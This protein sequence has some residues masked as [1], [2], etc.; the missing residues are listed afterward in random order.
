MCVWV[1]LRCMPSTFNLHVPVLLCHIQFPAIQPCYFLIFAFIQQWY[2]ILSTCVVPM[3]LLKQFY[4]D[5]PASCWVGKVMVLLWAVQLKPFTKTCS[6]PFSPVFLRIFFTG[7][8]PHT[9]SKTTK[10]IIYLSSIY[11]W[12]IFCNLSLCCCC[13]VVSSV[14]QN[15]FCQ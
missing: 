9:K 7:F 2:I 12:N 4:R 8:F 3:V 1:F 5:E 14:K 11:C 13:L 10:C 15:N 6:R